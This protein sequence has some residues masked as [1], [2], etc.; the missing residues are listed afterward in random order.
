MNKNAVENIEIGMEFNLKFKT[1]FERKK[2]TIAKPF[3]YKKHL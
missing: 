1:T 2:G 3:S